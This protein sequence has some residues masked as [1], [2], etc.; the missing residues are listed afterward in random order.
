MSHVLPNR[1]TQYHLSSEELST[2]SE[3]STL[4]LQLFQNLLAEAALQKLSLLYTPGEPLLYA[5]Q[6]AELQGKIGILEYLLT[7]ASSTTERE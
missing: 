2:A 1:F 7:L 3:F 6:E 4:Q 5:Q